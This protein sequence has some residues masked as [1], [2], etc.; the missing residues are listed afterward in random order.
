MSGELERT[1]LSDVKATA[2]VN[3]QMA[4]VLDVGSAFVESLTVGE[5]GLDA[6][7][8]PVPVDVQLN[9]VEFQLIFVLR[10]I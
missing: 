1:D 4:E 6:D 7:E 3:F 5:L 8:A 9:R 10:L 2:K